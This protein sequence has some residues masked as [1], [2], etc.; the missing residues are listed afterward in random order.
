[1][2]MNNGEA[3]SSSRKECKLRQDLSELGVI[4]TSMIGRQ[5]TRGKMNVQAVEK[6]I[7]DVKR[8]YMEEK[9]MHNVTITLR[10]RKGMI[11]W[12]PDE[13][14]IVCE[15]Q[16]KVDRTVDMLKGSPGQT[17]ICYVHGEGDLH[18]PRHT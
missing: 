1:M 8:F 15:Q 13:D 2:R 5:G 9:S 7:S 6:A 4:P 16:K 10:A 11:E 12:G 17:K 14:R 18:A 3:Y